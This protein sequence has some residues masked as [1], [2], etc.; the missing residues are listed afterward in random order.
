MMRSLVFCRGRTEL[1]YAPKNSVIIFSH[2]KSIT[3][4]YYMIFMFWYKDMIRFCFFNRV[5]IRGKNDGNFASCVI[6]KMQ[7]PVIFFWM[8]TSINKQTKTKIMIIMN[9]FL[10]YMHALYTILTLLS[11]EF[12]WYLSYKSA[13]RS[14]DVTSIWTV[15]F[16]SYNI[17]QATRNIVCVEFFLRENCQLKL[18]SNRMWRQIWLHQLT[19]FTLMISWF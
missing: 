18:S 12:L 17:F 9:S 13:E 7:F 6:R 16:V 11:S 8:D 10:E 19:Y 14:R 5:S 1:V 4:N 2:T 3:Y 15:K